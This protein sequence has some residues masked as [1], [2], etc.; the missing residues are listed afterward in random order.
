MTN[1]ELVKIAREIRAEG[2]KWKNSAAN[3]LH[4]IEQAKV[5]GT[6]EG[7][8]MA[9][10]IL[11]SHIPPEAYESQEGVNIQVGKWYRTFDSRRLRCMGT[12]LSPWFGEEK[13]VYCFYLQGSGSRYAQLD[14]KGKDVMGNQIIVGEVV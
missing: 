1:E 9:A 7:L 11:D 13:L 4:P 6:A 2:M 3:F 8:F 10:N 14:E 12:M 5:K